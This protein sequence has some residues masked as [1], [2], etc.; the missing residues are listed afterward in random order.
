M[1]TP[2]SGDILDPVVLVAL[3]ALNAFVR[4]DKTYIDPDDRGIAAEILHT[5]LTGGHAWTPDEIYGWAIRHA[6]TG[7]AA[8][9]LRDVASGVNAGRRIPKTKRLKPRAQLLEA[10]RRGAQGLGI[11]G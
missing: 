1:A 7:E 6:W 10:W 3:R 2:V 9:A 5:L 8:R 4:G 11:R